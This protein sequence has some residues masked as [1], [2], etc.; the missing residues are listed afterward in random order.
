MPTIIYQLEINWIDFG[1]I[2][3][4]YVICDAKIKIILRLEIC[5][6]TKCKKSWAYSLYSLT[7]I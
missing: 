7:Q 5:D 1:I 2:H 6:G 4:T 3:G